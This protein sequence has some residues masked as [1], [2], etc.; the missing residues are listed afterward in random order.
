MESA[1]KKVASATSGELAFFIQEKGLCEEYAR[2]AEEKSPVERLL[3]SKA[4]ARE[5]MNLLKEG[6]KRGY[7]ASEVADTLDAMKDG[8]KKACA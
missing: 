4:E 6:K 1:N 2:W 8:K 5:V 3:A 7:E